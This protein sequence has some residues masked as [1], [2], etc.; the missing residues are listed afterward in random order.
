MKEMERFAA[1]GDSGG[2]YTVIRW[3]NMTRFHDLDSGIITH[4]ESTVYQLLD[5]THVNIKGPGIF[6]IWD[7]EER[8]WEVLDSPLL[9]IQG[10]ASAKDSDADLLIV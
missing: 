9:K 8:I 3:I 10:S 7:T 2:R 6:E 1:Q 4:R 5:G